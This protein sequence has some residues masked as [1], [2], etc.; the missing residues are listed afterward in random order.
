MKNL[1]Y[2][3]LIRGKGSHEDIEFRQTLICDKSHTIYG[4]DRTLIAL[5]IIAEELCKISELLS[6]KI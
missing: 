4:K 3:E 2:L 1:E 5:E 6:K